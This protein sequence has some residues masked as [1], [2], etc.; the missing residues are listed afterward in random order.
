[1]RISGSVPLARKRI[2]VSAALGLVFGFRVVEIEFHAVE[3]FLAKD[4]HSCDHRVAGLERF[5]ARDGSVLHVIR[6]VQVDAAVLM[7]A[8]L[9]LEVGDKLAQGFAFLRHDV[10]KKQGIEKTVALGQVALEADTSGFF[11][12]HDDFA[13]QH[14]V[15]D[16]LEADAV[17]DQL[18]AVFFADAIQHFCRI[19]CARHGARPALAFEY[20]AEQNRKNL[21][22]IDEVAVLV[23]RADAIGVPV[24]AEA[25]VALIRDDC[26][27]KG[28]NMWL[29]RLGID[30]GK[31][32]IDVT[33]NLHVVD[34]DAGEDIGD[35]SAAGAVHGVNGE[36]HAGVR[37]E[38]EIGEDLDS[39]QIR[40][41]KIDFRNRRRLCGP[42]NGLAQIGFDGRNDRR[43]TRAAVPCFVLHAV[44]LRGIVGGRNH[45]A[46]RSAALAYSITQSGSRRDVVGEGNGNARSG[47]N[48]SAGVRESFR[49]EARV[50]ADAEAFRGILVG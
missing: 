18:A 39:L 14:V 12:A 34:A 48:F 19:E 9:G 11:A 42:R 26:F 46:A 6:D 47:D 50:I 13:L 4:R 21:V 44:P 17:L 37:D 49:T 31:Q 1:M 2:H 33:A 36:F 28:A 25:G 27:A 41:Q 22:W 5:G 40:G 43:L 45:D 23:G 16:E 10:G 30:A 20:P 15:A 38:I 3:V 24:G 32:R 8:V 29:D 35:E 7:L